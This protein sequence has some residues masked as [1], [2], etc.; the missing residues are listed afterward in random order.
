MTESAASS[1][2]YHF[3]LAILT[4]VTDISIEGKSVN[5]SQ[6]SRTFLSHC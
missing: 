5:H 4:V 1:N 2:L 6:D 3:D